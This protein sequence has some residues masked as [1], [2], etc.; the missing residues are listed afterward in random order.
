MSGLASSVIPLLSSWENYLSTHPEGDIPGFAR[1]VLSQQHTGP[2]TPK[3]EQATRS[4][5]PSPSVQQSTAAPSSLIPP[6]AELD[7]NAQGA[8]L[9]TRLHGLLRLYSKPIIKELGFT[10]DLEFGVLVHVAIMNRPNKKE[11]CRQLLIENSTGVEVTRRLAKRGLITEQPD[12]NDRRSARLSVTEKGKQIIYRGYEKLAPFHT[13]F[14]DAL[15]AEEKRQL[16]TLLSR[17]NQYH[18]SFVYLY[19]DDK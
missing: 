11:L 4:A 3:P 9:I 15:T 13:S 1:W 6:S 14:L 17:I 16:V 18:S 10:K 5:G 7:D 2:S 8:L 12:P 19:G